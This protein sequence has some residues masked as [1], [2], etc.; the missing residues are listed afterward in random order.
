MSRT[1]VIGDVHGCYAALLRVLQEAGYE[2]GADRLVFLGDL[3][4]RGPDSKAVLT[5]VLDHRRVVNLRGNHEIMMLDAR[6]DTE[7]AEYWMSCGGRETVL[8]YGELDDNWAGRVPEIHWRLLEA[9]RP[10]YET[11]DYILVHATPNAAVQMTA[12]TESHLFW[13]KC[14]R[15]IPGPHVSGKTVVCGHTAQKTGA[16]LDVG[17]FICIDT[18]AYGDGWLSCLDLDTLAWY[19]ASRFGAVRAGHLP[20]RVR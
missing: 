20:V 7:M 4:D 8:S 16:I 14:R 6:A 15:E 2:P 5:W 10:W 19:Q 18:W 9:A 3:V 13:E 1:L 11:D 17:H 12:Q